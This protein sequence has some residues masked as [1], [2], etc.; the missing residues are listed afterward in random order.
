MKNV[1]V[2]VVLRQAKTE[3]MRLL[4]PRGVFPV[5]MGGKSLENGVVASIT[6]FFI[7]YM[8]LFILG[9]L[10]MAGLGLDVVT[11]VGSVAATLGNIGPGLGG[12]GPVQNYAAIPQVGKWVLCGFMLLGRLEIYTVLL[13]LLPA[14][15]R[16]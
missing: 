11:S 1:R 4:H 15:W 10:I 13:L 9:T 16:R 14:T 6:A 8:G 2:M 5:R 12:V 3:M 7:L